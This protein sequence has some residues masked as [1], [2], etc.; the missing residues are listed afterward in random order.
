M[1]A[2]NQTDI[3]KLEAYL[4]GHLNFEVY[5]NGTPAEQAEI[6]IIDILKKIEELAK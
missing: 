5:K 1:A 4:R 3:Q 2:A 6:R